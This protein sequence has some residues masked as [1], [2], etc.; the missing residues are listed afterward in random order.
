MYKKTFGNERKFAKTT[1]FFVLEEKK[2]Y[3]F[4]FKLATNIRIHVGG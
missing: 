3:H 4:I 1:I 2:S